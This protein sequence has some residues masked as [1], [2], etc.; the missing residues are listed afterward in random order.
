[1]EVPENLKIAMQLDCQIKKMPGVGSCLFSCG[2]EW[3]FGGVQNMKEFRKLAHRFIIENWEYYHQFICLP[4]NETIGVGSSAP[5]V[6]I[7]TYAEMR[8]FL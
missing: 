1:M 6:K 3:I 8:K 2:S 4:F 5:S 7:E